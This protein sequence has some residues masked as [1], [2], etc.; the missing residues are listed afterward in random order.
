MRKL[1][2]R[3]RNQEDMDILANGLSKIYGIVDLSNGNL[4]KKVVFGGNVEVTRK[5]ATTSSK[6]NTIGDYYMQQWVDMPEFKMDFKKSDYAKVEMYFNDE[7]S[8]ETLGILFQQGV[9]DKTKSIWFP[10]LVHGSN[11]NIRVIGGRKAKYPIYVVSKNRSDIGKM[12][13]SYWLSNMH[14]PHTIIVEEQDVAKYECTYG[15]SKY[16]TIL[17]LPQKYKDEY[18]VFDEN[19]GQKGTTGPGAARNF[20]MEHSKVNGSTWCWVLDDNTEFPG[21]CRYYRGRRIP[22]YSAEVFRNLED[23]VDRYENIG[24]AGLNYSKFCI[25]ENN[26]PPYTTNTRIYSFLLLRNDLPYRWRGRYNE[27]TDLSLRMLKDGWCTVQQNC[28]VACKVTTQKVKGGNTEEFY[29][30]EGTKA[31]SQ[32]L[33]DMHPDVAK[34]VWKFSRWHHEVDYSGFKQELK[35]KEEYKNILEEKKGVINEHGVRIVRIPKEDVRTEKDNLDY[36][37]EHYDNEDYYVDEDIFLV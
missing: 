36:I 30:L 24:Q 10:K 17:T 31:K 20:A 32:M 34:L 11:N 22:C 8:L 29:A 13:I 18:D 2:V 14:Q 21:F 19:M 23:F 12:H 35:L 16:C 3:F 6:K 26:Y 33:V 25:D 37:L 9:T 5:K 7:T 4:I 27:D 1:I 28:Y 15:L